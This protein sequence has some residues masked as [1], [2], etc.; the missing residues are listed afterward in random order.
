[1]I[2]SI[3]CLIAFANSATGSELVFSP[4]SPF[5]SPSFAAFKSGI[6]CESGLCDPCQCVDWQKCT[7]PNRDCLSAKPFPLPK[8]DKTPAIVVT[9]YS[10]EGCGPCRAY[11]PAFARQSTQHPGVT[12]AHAGIT[13]GIR[14]YPT[15]IVTRDGRE[16]ARFEG[17]VSDEQMAAAI[18]GK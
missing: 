17:A 15:V 14:A 6:R 2:R 18:S 16:T 3:L 7:T 9:L 5:P 10:F 12:F 13:P 1:M 11:K 4:F 8:A